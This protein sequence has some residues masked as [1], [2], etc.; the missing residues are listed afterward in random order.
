MS[1]L[2]SVRGLSAGY[3]PV[4]VLHGVDLEVHEGQVAV[5]LGANGAGK[6]TMLRAISGMIPRAGEIEFA[7]RNIVK[8]P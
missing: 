8:A 2:L 3:G 5:I 4:E 1:A 7:G 6:T